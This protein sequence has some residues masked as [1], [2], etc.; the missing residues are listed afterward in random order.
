ME[1]FTINAGTIFTTIKVQ[2][3]VNETPG[4]NT[5]ELLEGFGEN[6]F[7]SEEGSRIEVAQPICKIIL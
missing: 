3:N 2:R 6:L 4:I 5:E 1:V 7:N